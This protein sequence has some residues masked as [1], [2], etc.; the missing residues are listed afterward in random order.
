LPRGGGNF[1]PIQGEVAEELRLL[2]REQPDATS[3][4]L[5]DALIDKTGV[6]TS[7]SGVKRALHRLGFTPKKKSFVAEERDQPV[8]KWR[9]RILAALLMVIDVRRLVFLD[10]SFCNTSM[11]REY[12]W[13]PLG[14]RCWAKR[15]GGHWKTLTL[16]GAIRVGQKPKLTTHIGSING[17]VFLRYV[18]RRL[19]PWLRP[20]D[21]VLMDNL[22][23][24]KVAGVREAI[25]AA[26][27]WVIYL[28]PYSP[29]FN[30][31]ELW[32]P[33][34]KRPL[35]TSAPRNL[36]PLAAVAQQGRASTSIENVNAWFSHAL[37]FTQLN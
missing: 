14:R 12:G 6:E 34:L 8:L 16:I 28:P 2:V 19:V 35:R 29:D 5:A 22:K 24:H 1:S 18:R 26:G 37:R 31:I 4:E 30:P 25:E 21:I 23:A 36:A 13:A 9:R 17:D 32:W 33:N 20:G 27:A 11:A 3:Q 15:P 7:P 10:E